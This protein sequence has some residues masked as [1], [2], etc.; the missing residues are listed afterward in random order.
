M[1]TTKPPVLTDELDPRLIEW[2]RARQEQHHVLLDQRA[3]RQVIAVLERARADAVRDRTLDQV[4]EILERNEFATRLQSA[5]IIRALKGTPAA[6]V[7][8]AP[9]FGCSEEEGEDLMAAYLA[10]KKAG[11][12]SGNAGEVD[13]ARLDFLDRMNATLNA[14]YGTNYRWKLVLSHNITRLMVGK[15]WGG[16]VGDVDLNDANHDGLSSCRDAID[17]AIAASKGANHG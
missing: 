11:Q 6:G 1:N 8:D 3:V 5:M 16:Y 10:G 9:T 4:I 2:L 17:A 7:A 12:L 15:H 13:T 14:H